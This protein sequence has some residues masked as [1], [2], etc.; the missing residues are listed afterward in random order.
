MKKSVIITVLFVV[1]SA[2]ARDKNSKD[3]V[4]KYDKFKDQT[5]VLLEASV[6]ERRGSVK[7]AGSR[8]GFSYMCPG[9]RTDCHP[10]VIAF[11]LEHHSGPAGWDLINA[12]SLILLADDKRI[13]AQDVDW[14]GVNM[15]WGIERLTGRLTPEDLGTLVAAH[16]VSLQAGPLEG[17]LPEKARR[18][19]RELAE[20]AR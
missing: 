20:M 1:A 2:L 16:H 11:L 17:D 10:K 6:P 14:H 7:L 13:E 5:L 8:V 3:I 12:R 9:E 4:I 15:Y 19:W 18:G